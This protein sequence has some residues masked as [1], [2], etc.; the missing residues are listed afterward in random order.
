MVRFLLFEADAQTGIRTEDGKTAKSLID[1]EIQPEVHEDLTALFEEY[2][3]KKKEE[4]EEERKREGE[5]EGEEDE[6][7]I[8]VDV[9][10]LSENVA[11]LTI[12]G[13]SLQPDDGT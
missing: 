9:N 1:P 6:D 13:K 2:E 5:G 12:S 7:S 10:Q 3:K 11:E 4:A 8:D